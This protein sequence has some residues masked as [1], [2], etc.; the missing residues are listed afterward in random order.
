MAFLC[1]TALDASLYLA[2]SWDLGEGSILNM[3]GAP[4]FGTKR[5]EKLR[6]EKTDCGAAAGNPPLAATARKGLIAT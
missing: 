4:T 1:F 2:D 3:L 5:A 6:I